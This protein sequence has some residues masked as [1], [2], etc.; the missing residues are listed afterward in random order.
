MLSRPPSDITPPTFFESWLPKQ[1][2]ELSQGLTTPPPDI[3]VNVDI[4]GDGGGQ[5]SLAL[6]GGALAITGGSTDSASLAFVQSVDDWY[7]VTTGK[8]EESLGLELPEDSF[9]S[10]DKLLVHPAL[11]RVAGA[12]GAVK[13][14]LDFEITHDGSKALSARL[15]FQGATDPQA[16]IAIGSDTL[17]EMR[18]GKLTAPEA[19]FSGKILVTGES[20]LAMQLGMMMMMP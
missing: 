4:T 6:S 5:W 1:Y 19:F 9:T 8:A 14:T 2:E 7:A 11:G 12:V 20:A 13:G 10:L 17:S 16:T 3:V 15:I 18:S